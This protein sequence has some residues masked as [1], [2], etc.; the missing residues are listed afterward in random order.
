METNVLINKLK[1][2]Q[3]QKPIK[4]NVGGTVYATSIDTLI[5]SGNTYFSMMF[6]DKWDLKRDDRDDTYF[7]DRDPFVFSYI[8]NFLRTSTISKIHLTPLQL[9]FLISDAEF[10][11]IEALISILKP[12]SKQNVAAPTEKAI[13][14]I[15][16]PDTE[17]DYLFKLLIIGDAGVGKSGLIL[18]YVDN[19]F[20]D[21]YIS[22]IG[23]DFKQKIIQLNSSLIKLQIW[24]TAGQE[25]F[26]TITSSYYRG[27]H[28]IIIV[29][30]VTDLESFEN[31]KKWLSEI[32]RYANENTKKLIM[33]NKCDLIDRKAVEYSTAKEFADSLGIPLIE[34]SAKS[35]VNV[36]QAFESIALEIKNSLR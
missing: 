9:E 20:T 30:D 19:S 8:L 2:S 23:V 11:Q 28:G 17:Y 36:D 15:V 3:V 27:A 33:G 26:R 5:S 34:V 32:D 7:I 35:A 12:D 4:L 22:T 14:K 25:R 31:T 13:E 29:Y 10:Y 21:S 16:Q 24:D 1:E 18:R 6:S